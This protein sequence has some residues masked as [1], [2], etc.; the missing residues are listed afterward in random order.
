MNFFILFSSFLALIY[1]YTGLRL[2]KGLV[3][4]RAARLGAWLLLVTVFSMLVAHIWFRVTD[5]HP[6]LSRICAWTGYTGLGVI[7]YLFCLTLTRDLL[8]LVSLCALKTGQVLKPGAAEVNPDRRRFL[9]RASGAAITGASL[10]AAGA[11]GR[12]ALGAPEVITI[13][14]PLDRGHKGLSGMTIAQFTDLHVGAMVK[15]PYVTRVCD[16][17]DGLNADLIA[18]TGDLV[19]G[20]PRHLATDVAPLSRLN[21]P[22]GK[23]FI[24]GNHEYYSGVHRWLAAVGDL[25]FTPLINQHRILDYQGTPFTLAGVTDIRTGVWFKGHESSPAK[26]FNGTPDHHFKLLLAHQPTS[27]LD[28]ADLGVDLQLSGHTHGGQYFPFNFFIHMEHPYVKGLFRVRKTRLYV[29]QG[30][31]Y[32]GPPLRLGTVPEITLFRLV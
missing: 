27:V 4:G 19:D 28:A 9:V 2:I 5:T 26:A 14:I 16:T 17:I 8:F 12:I 32:W 31:G 15:A 11:G 22:L 23:Y 29:N 3:P 13:D 24:T 18:F 7:S 30:T 1:T 21:A 25:G 6:E 20:D 10:L